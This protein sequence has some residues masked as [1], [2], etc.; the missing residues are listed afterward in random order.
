MEIDKD[1]GGKRPLSIP[2]VRDRVAQMA[3]K[4]VL[5]PIF[6]MDLHDQAYG[7]RPNRS[8]L[9]AVKKVRSGLRDGYPHV[10]DADVSGYFDNIPHDQLLKSVANR[11]SDG[12]ILAL[13]KAWLKVPIRKED[14]NGKVTFSGGES[15]TKGTPQGGVISPL[16]ANIYI[17]R[18]LK[19][20]NRYGK[21]EKFHAHL[22][23]YADDFVVLCRTKRG[24]REALEW[25]R[26]A[27]GAM[28]LTLNREKTSICN[29]N[30]D[31]FN[32]LGYTF[33][34]KY[35]KFTGTSYLAATPSDESV[36]SLKERVKRILKT[37]RGSKWEEVVEEL[38]YLLTG[39]ANYYSYGTL[40]ATYKAINHYVYDVVV[41]FLSR[42]QKLSTRNTRIFPGDRVFGVL[43]VCKLAKESWKQ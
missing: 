5:E 3:A 8:C 16:L 41:R 24:A 29:A 43:G 32:F 25:I 23:N 17:N 19:A 30:L 2:T 42:R 27:I 1:T 18:L 28:G 10:V 31:D 38:N 6:E 7:Y 4:L 9:D 13:I 20:W 26:N 37:S 36:K 40:N 33:G 34:R 39:W 15:S 21:P 14:D 11:V 22:V 35:H 12:S